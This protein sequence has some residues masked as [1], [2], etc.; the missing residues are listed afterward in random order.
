MRRT[1]LIICLAAWFLLLSLV[2]SSEGRI[3]YVDD[4]ATGSNDGSNW[5]NA[6]NYL[7]D[8]LADAKSSPKPVEIRVAQD[9]HKPDQGAYQI[10]GNHTATFQLINGIT[11]KGGY[12]GL[13][14]TDPRA[15]DV[16]HYEMVLRGYLP[17]ND[18][19]V[20]GH[21]ATLCFINLGRRSHGRGCNLKA[22]RFLPSSMV[23]PIGRLKAE[24]MRHGKR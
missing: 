15:R 11:L 21:C 13:G 18:M 3:I 6:Y 12:A 8:A 17:D 16:Q 14:H 22:S 9:I 10:P 5:K 2:N 4:D 1:H 19:R 7:Q 20:S 23:M 24:L